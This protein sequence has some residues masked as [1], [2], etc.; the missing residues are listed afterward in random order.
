MAANS[1]SLMA[2]LTMAP[3]AF[4]SGEL[5][6]LPRIKSLAA[7][8]TE[9]ERQFGKLPARDLEALVGWFNRNFFRLEK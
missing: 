5:A 4:A 7:L 9:V 6:A 1:L 3:S 8:K 2:L